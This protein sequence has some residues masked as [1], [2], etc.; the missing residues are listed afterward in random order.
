LED[1]DF[2]DNAQPA[3]KLSSVQKLLAKFN[4]KNPEEKLVKRTYTLI[5]DIAH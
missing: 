5:N 2:D 3:K 4:I 1:V